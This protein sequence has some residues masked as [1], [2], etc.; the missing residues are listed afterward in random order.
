MD[1]TK[2]KLREKVTFL[3]LILSFVEL[4]KIVETMGIL[5]SAVQI[6]VSHK[7]SSHKPYT[8]GKNF[9]F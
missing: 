6:H 4:N 7:C 8:D 5:L 1:T 9:F 2:S 3:F